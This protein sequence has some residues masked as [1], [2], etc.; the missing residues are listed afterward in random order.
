MLYGNLHQGG[1]VREEVPLS[2]YSHRQVKVRISRHAA[3]VIEQEDRI[4]K[5]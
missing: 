5:V 2:N 3:T 4:R 1:R